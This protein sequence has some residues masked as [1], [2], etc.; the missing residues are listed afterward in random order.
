[1]VLLTACQTRGHRPPRSVAASDS[2]ARFKMDP[3]Q[4][5]PKEILLRLFRTV[6]PEDLVTLGQLNKPWRSLARDPEIWKDVELEPD[7]CT[8]RDAVRVIRSAPKLK[9][10]ELDS[11]ELA[12]QLLQ[13][14]TEV[15][16]LDFYKYEDSPDTLKKVVRKFAD[17]LESLELGSLSPD[18]LDFLVETEFPKLHS[19]TLSGSSDDDEVISA[20]DYSGRWQDRGP[21]HSTLRELA[22][23]SVDDELAP[24]MISLITAHRHTLAEL[25]V[26]YING[27]HEEQMLQAVS[28]CSGLS[29][30]TLF[31]SDA[32]HVLSHKLPSLR[33]LELEYILEDPALFLLR[34]R[35]QGV[36]VTFDNREDLTRELRQDL[37]PAG[38]LPGLE[39][40]RLELT[41]VDVN[42]VVNAVVRCAP[43]L[44][45]LRTLTVSA[46]SRWSDVVSRAVAAALPHVKLV[47]DM[48]DDSEDDSDDDSDD[49]SSVY[50]DGD[51]DVV[52]VKF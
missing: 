39:E 10:L 12:E 33:S 23:F 13:S 15:T 3:L 35:Q 4:V 19:L 47:L 24:A 28:Q 41:C 38:L 49:G 48:V 14:N 44:A 32:L 42:Q 2:A 16:R 7:H 43:H 30:L 5:L 36:E 17:R 25:E 9:S 27:E 50:E 46:S 29:R 45:A 26:G 37:L 40:L 52:L 22:L 34:A 31:W 18:I 6:S 51:V 21:G 20:S 11:E 8:V 1:M